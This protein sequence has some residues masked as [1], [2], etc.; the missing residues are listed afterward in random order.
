MFCGISQAIR[1]FFFLHLSFIGSNP[2]G[3]FDSSKRA[4][5]AVL[6]ALNVYRAM[7]FL[8]CTAA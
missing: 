2:V 6:A 3:G 5:F 1:C 7:L 4:L 8:G